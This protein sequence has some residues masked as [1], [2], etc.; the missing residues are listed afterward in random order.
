MSG[1]RIGKKVKLFGKNA[2]VSIGASGSYF[3]TWI[4]GYRISKFT[5]YKKRR[6]PLEHAAKPHKYTKPQDLSNTRCLET[7]ET[8][9]EWKCRRL[10]EIRIEQEQEE[11]R[12]AD[13]LAAQNTS[14]LS[15]W[16]IIFGVWGFV[17]ILV[18]VISL[19]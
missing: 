17:A 16:W 2:F 14:T 18:K 4:G 6:D 7:G 19:V 12:A 1:F 9:S 5:S 13:V 11:E 8:Y 3:S 10:K 15:W